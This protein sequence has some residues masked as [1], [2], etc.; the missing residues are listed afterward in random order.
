MKQ[1]KMHKGEIDIDIALVKRLLAEQFPHLAE[2][3]ITLVRSMG[4]V[5]AI[6]RLGD[7]FCIRLPR[8][9]EWS[10]GIENEQFWLPKFARH[11]SLNIPK[12]LARGH[13]V[14]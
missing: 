13:R 9:E 1:I 12:P 5:N 8:L 7:E 11:I 3:S 14:R 6:F 10:E 4:T 2:M